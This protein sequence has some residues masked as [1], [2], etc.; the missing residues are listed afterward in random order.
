MKEAAGRIFSI[1]SDHAPVPGCTVSREI[2]D[3]GGN[4]VTYFSLAASTDI[5]AETFPYYKF[6][7]VVNSISF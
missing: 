6:L 3:T 4:T 5:S 7:L 1:A 2:A